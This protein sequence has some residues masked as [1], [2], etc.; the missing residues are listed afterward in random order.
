MDKTKRAFVGGLLAAAMTAGAAAPSF[1]Q[2][3]I[4]IQFWH[5]MGGVLGERVDEVVKRYN[6]SQTKFTVVATN[7]GNYD[8]V[9]NGTIAAY[10]AKKAP[11]VVQI[12]ERGF[13]SMLLSGAIEPVQDLLTARNRKVDF[14]D[15][16]KPVASYYQYKG[17]LMSMPFNSSTPILFYNKEQFE[18]AGFAA[19]AATWA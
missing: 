10:R 12:Y 5:A 8:E 7:K 6:D 15:F 16:I 3:R 1:A 18:K 13:M 9:I 2:Q 14:A 17:K 19:P 11:H 4:E